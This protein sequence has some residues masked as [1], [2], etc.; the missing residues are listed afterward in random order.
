[1]FCKFRRKIV[2]ATTEEDA[3]HQGTTVTFW[4]FTQSVHLAHFMIPFFLT[5]GVT[6]SRTLD[7]KHRIVDVMGGA[8]V[9]FVC[10]VAIH[11]SQYSSYEYFH[12]VLTTPTPATGDS[13]PTVNPNEE[14]AECASMVL[15][16]AMEQ[17]MIDIPEP[18]INKTDAVL[19][20]RVLT[21]RTLTPRVY[22]PRSSARSLNSPFPQFHFNTAPPSLPTTTHATPVSHFRSLTIPELTIPE[23]DSADIEN[24]KPVECVIEIQGNKYIASRSTV[25]LIAV[26]D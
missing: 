10:A 6:F 20:P 26:T 18:H 12:K 7:D 14:V 24:V 4:S 22:T 9:G 16:S 13:K 15:Q 3:A 1:M 5:I 19:T 23:N 2:I 8:I 21:P 11:G 25:N 17:G